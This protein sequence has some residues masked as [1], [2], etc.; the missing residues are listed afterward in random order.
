M[1]SLFQIMILALG[2]GHPTQFFLTIT[3]YIAST[4][5]CVLLFVLPCAVQTGYLYFPLL[6]YV[7]LAL[8]YGL[9]IGFLHFA[10]EFLGFLMPS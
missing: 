8:F 9:Q 6:F 4:H 2:C 1:S 7:P 3:K 5:S 10:Y